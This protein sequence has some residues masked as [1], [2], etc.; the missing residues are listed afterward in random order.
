MIQQISVCFSRL[1]LSRREYRG[2]I[3]DITLP[4]PGGVTDGTR[5]PGGVV[6]E[7]CDL[8]QRK[9]DQL[10]GENAFRQE[11]DMPHVGHT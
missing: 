6:S 9:G 4:V 11:A 3:F 7:L 1:S 2:H 5:G 8:L 10:Q